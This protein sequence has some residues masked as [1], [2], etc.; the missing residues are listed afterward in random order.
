MFAMQAQAPAQSEAVMLQG[1]YWDSNN[2]TSWSQLYQISGD[3]SARFDYVWLPPSAFS[4]GGTG[5]IPRQWSTQNGAWGTRAELQ[6][7]IN[8]LKSNGCK[9]IADIV[10]N[11]RG[12][13][14]VAPYTSF[15]PDDFGTYG[16]FQLLTSDICSNDDV[17]GTGGADTGDGFDGARDLDHNST[18][19]KNAIKAYLEW[20]K[21]DIGYDGWRYDMVKGFTSSV[22]AGYNAAANADLSVGEYWDGD[23][24]AVWNWIIGTGKNSMAFDCPMKYTALNQ[25][26]QSSNYGNMAYNAHPAG[27]IRDAQSRRYSVTF[28]DNHDTYRDASKYT[29]SVTKAYAFI[30]SS[31]GIPCVFYP[32]WIE[33]KTAI[34]NMIMARKAAGIN[35]ESEVQVQQTSGYYKSYSIGKYGAL[36]TYIGSSSSDWA[37][38][39]PSGGGWTLECS[40]TGWAIYVNTTATSGAPNPSNAGRTA[41]QSKIS[42][43]VNPPA[44]NNF[45]SI[46]ITAIVP[47]SWT[48]PKIHVWNKGITGAP[49]ITTPSTWPGQAMTHVEGNKWTI[50]LPSFTATKVVGIVIN[51]GAATATQQTFDLTATKSQSCWTVASTAMVGNYFDATESEDCFASSVENNEVGLFIIYPNPVENVL[52]INSEKNISKMSVFNAAGQTVILSKEKETDVSSL[53]KGIYLLEIKFD[54]SSIYFGKF[55]KK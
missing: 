29:G 53:Q 49:A 3:I 37:S 1:F 12:D 51:N 9:S 45:T 2:A 15:F 20:M 6:K 14:G 34:N 26:L 7:L 33:Y 35:S 4:T 10:V 43:G 24:T 23:Y 50:I 27:L 30:L 55:V 47:A 42:N 38:D 54:D 31:A 40:G 44:I 41:Y 16:Q 46:T 17:P 25:G 8:A 18:N 28:V 11:H 22:I 13:N 5:Y 32:H 36:L 52:K 21:N 48:A 19:V 39:A